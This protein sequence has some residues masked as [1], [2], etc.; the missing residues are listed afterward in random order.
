MFNYYLLK[1]IE[2]GVF[3]VIENHYFGEHARQER[4]GMLEP[5][6]LGYNNVMFPFNCLAFSIFTALAIAAVEAVINKCRKKAHQS[7]FHVKQKQDSH[8][9]IIEEVVEVELHIHETEAGLDGN[10]SH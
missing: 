8:N 2:V 10:G 1:E 5:Q 6:P 4:F 7:L 9:Q 3:R